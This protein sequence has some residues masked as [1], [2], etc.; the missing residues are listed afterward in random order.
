MTLITDTKWATS[1]CHALQEILTHVQ[2]E[3][4]VLDIQNQ[5]LDSH[6]LENLTLFY[7]GIRESFSEHV[8]SLRVA[9]PTVMQVHDQYLLMHLVGR[10]ADV[11]VGQPLHTNT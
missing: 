11:E 1:S 4:K 9:L 7:P 5:G 3:I 6:D 8:H 2:H 10:I